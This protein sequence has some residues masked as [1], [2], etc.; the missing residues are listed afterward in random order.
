MDN[1][2]KKQNKKTAKSWAK[3]KGT[4]FTFN[5]KEEDRQQ[6]KNEKLPYLIQNSKILMY[7]NGNLCFS[8]FNVGVFV[9][10]SQTKVMLP[11]C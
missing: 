5:F 11:F 2:D 1:K 3:N 7:Y 4:L 6:A 8:T 10:Y 9:F